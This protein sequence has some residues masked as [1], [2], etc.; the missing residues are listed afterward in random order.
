MPDM[1]S[2]D[3]KHWWPIMFAYRGTVLKRVYRRVLFYG[4][5]TLAFWA[6]DSYLTP[7]PHVDPLGP[8]LVGVALGLLIVFR[9]NS[10]YDRY[11][12][13]RKLWGTMAGAARNLVRGAAAYGGPADDLARLT[14]GDVV[15]LK[16]QL[17]DSRDLAEVKPLVSA[18]VFGRACAAA[19]PALALAFYLS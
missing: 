18:E 3:T 10:S 7:L 8:S 12:E 2:Y 15:A 16:Q 17:R 1:I 14:A 4:L 19:N 5:L 11:W 9:T 13:G 6:W